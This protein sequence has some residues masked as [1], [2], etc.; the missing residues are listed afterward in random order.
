[1]VKY[2]GLFLEEAAENL[3]DMGKALLDL[4]KDTASAES[5]DVIFR[6]AHSIKSMA[7]SVGH[8]PIA[9][10]ARFFAT[11]HADRFWIFNCCPELPYPSA[12]FGTEAECV[13]GGVASP[14]MGLAAETRAMLVA[15]V[16][17]VVQEAV[18]LGGVITKVIGSGNWQ[19]SMQAATMHPGQTHL[20][21]FACGYR[22]N[23]RYCCECN[24]S[25]V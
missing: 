12:A 10:V 3:A 1:M 9:E 2:R 14:S 24:L 23:H 6:M 16:D 18:V 21:V 5:I 8:D 17:V 19:A 15:T 11:R 7:A 20:V 13:I 4:E 25:M 22:D